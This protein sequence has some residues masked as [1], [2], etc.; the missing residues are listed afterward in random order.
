MIV[1][2]I[3]FGILYIIAFF[4]NRLTD[5]KDARTASVCLLTVSTMFF[6]AALF[7]YGNEDVPTAKDVYEG[8]TT[9]E[10]TYRDSTPIDTIIV[11]KDEFKK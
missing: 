10:I 3:V 11:F 7:S 2:M 4:W 1:V 9:L 8:K 5:D 6:F